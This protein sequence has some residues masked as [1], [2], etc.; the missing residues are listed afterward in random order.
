MDKLYKILNIVHSG[1]KG[2]RYDE[3]QD[4][5]YDG[6]VGATIKMPEIESIK[7]FSNVR[8]DFVS[9]GPI[10]YDFWTTSPVVS[11]SLD[12]SNHYVLETINTIYILEKHYDKRDTIEFN[13]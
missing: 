10:Y 6:M 8:W 3:V 5:K 12:F 1:R 13:T 7:Q 11:V 2:M 9:D 4:P